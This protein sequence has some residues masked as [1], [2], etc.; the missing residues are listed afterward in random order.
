MENTFYRTGIKIIIFSIM[1]VTLL[2]KNAFADG[3][4]VVRDPQRTRPFRS[5]PFPLE[6]KYHRVDTK[7]KDL[8]AE[9]YIDQVFYNPLNRR[10]EGYYIFPIPRGAVIKKFSMFING[11]ETYAELLDAKKARKI[12]EDIVRK[13]LDPA[14]LEYEGQNIFKAR[15]FPIEANSKKG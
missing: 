5:N 7:I 4:I 14:I 11:K 3:F 13:Q 2:I 1:I 12:Y 9:T 6:V 10:L 8:A 15:I